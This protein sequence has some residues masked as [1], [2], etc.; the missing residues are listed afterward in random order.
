MKTLDVVCEKCA[1]KLG[2][3]TF[4]DETPD[5]RCQWSVTHGYL[6][7]QCAVPPQQEEEPNV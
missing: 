5:E 2:E 3:A 6:C 4:P 1:K 7:E